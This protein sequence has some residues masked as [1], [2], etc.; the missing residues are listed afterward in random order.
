[1]EISY[2]VEDLQAKVKRLESSIRFLMKLM[3]V[4]THRYQTPNE[5]PYNPFRSY[6]ETEMT[7][8]SEVDRS[9]MEL[10]K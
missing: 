9:Q 5:S 2:A 3:S 4:H 7:E 6:G 8:L 1:M 10:F